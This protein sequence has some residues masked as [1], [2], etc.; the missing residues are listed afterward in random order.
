MFFLVRFPLWVINLT[1]VWE[2]F[3]DQLYPMA[4]VSILPRSRKDFVDRP[5]NV[6][7]FGSGPID[8]LKL[9]ELPL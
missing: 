8:N 6:L 2:A 9:S 1:K 3:H 5:L 7:I 4:L